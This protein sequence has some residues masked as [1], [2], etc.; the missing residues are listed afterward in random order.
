MSVRAGVNLCALALFT[1]QRVGTEGKTLPAI[2]YQLQ[3]EEEGSQTSE[4][5]WHLRLNKERSRIA[6]RVCSVN[7]LPGLYYAPLSLRLRPRN[8]TD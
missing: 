8:I 1:V 6:R 2:K 4:E 3:E 5:C 7:F